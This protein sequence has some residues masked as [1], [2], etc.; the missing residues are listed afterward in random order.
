M[1]L[2]PGAYGLLEMTQ[3]NLKM[4]LS[5]ESLRKQQAVVLEVFEKQNEATLVFEQSEA[6]ES[7]EDP[8]NPMQ[9]MLYSN[10]AFQ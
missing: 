9:E 10:K 7:R 6:N 4:F 2:L 3:S 1:M 8:E 5:M